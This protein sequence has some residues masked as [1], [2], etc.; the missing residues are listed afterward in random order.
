MPAVHTPPSLAQYW[1]SL[2][3]LRDL[4]SPCIPAALS[5]VTLSQLTMFT[6]ATSSVRVGPAYTQPPEGRGVSSFSSWWPVSWRQ[7]VSCLSTPC[8]SREQCCPHPGARAARRTHFHLATAEPK[9]A[10]SNCECGDPPN[11]MQH[12]ILPGWL[13]PESGPHLHRGAREFPNIDADVG[14]SILS[15]GGITAVTCQAGDTCVH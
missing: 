5:Q 7:P 15:G 8:Y 3:F 11:S 4:P 13:Q 12:P 9:V 2:C 10:R 1:P 14:G 6:V